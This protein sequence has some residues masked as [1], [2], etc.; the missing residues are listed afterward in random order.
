LAEKP[1]GGAGRPEQAL[2]L[3]R[4]GIVANPGYWR[5]WQDL[6]FIY[7]WDLKDYAN[8]ARWFKAGGERPGAMPWMKTLAATVVAQGG[9]VETSRALWAELYRDAGNDQLRR[10]AAEHLAAFD[11]QD[12]MAKL[13]VLLA[14]FRE[15]H[16]RP[17]RSWQE[18]AAA[19]LLAA[20][21]K[22]PSGAPYRI[23]GDGAAHLGPGSQI[24]LRLVE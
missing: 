22:D 14:Q 6:G 15:N 23:G 1:P 19:G 4:R 5:L 24:S 20:V 21:P 11:A 3:L 17:A 12:Q 7:Y 18:L 2:Q 10:S 8:A 16:G 13:D 9:E